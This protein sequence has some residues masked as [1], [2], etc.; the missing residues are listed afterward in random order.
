MTAAYQRNGG[1]KLGHL[2]TM[3]KTYCRWFDT[4]ER[5]QNKSGQVLGK[6]LGIF[7]YGNA[8][9]MCI[10]QRRKAEA[11]CQTEDKRGD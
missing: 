5:F 2:Q 1:Q 10:S 7:V 4:L 9:H 6:M 3:W 11:N 8:L